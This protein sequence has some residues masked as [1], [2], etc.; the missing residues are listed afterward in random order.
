MK[1]AMAIQLTPEQEDR[2]RAVVSSGAYRSAEEALNAALAAVESA[3]AAT[4]LSEAE[5]EGLLLKGL[6]SRE[7]SEEEFWDSVDRDTG[8]MLST[9]ERRPRP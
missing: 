3:S 6:A 9:D 8:A 1:L 2:I 7:L 4:E 5:I